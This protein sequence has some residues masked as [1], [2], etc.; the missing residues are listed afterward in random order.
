MKTPKHPKHQSG[1]ALMAAMIALVV[2]AIAAIALIRTVDTGVLVAGNLAFRQ[3]AVSAGDAGIEAARTWMLANRTALNNDTTSEG[4]Y[5]NSQSGVDLTGNT[6]TSTSDDVAWNGTGVSTPKCLATDARGNTVC[7]IIHRM[8]DT[9]GGAIDAATC[10]TKTGSV[11]GSS[12]GG[13]RQMETYQQASWSDVTLFAYYRV[14]VRVAGPRNNI[15][16][17]Q[18]FLII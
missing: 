14:T 12:Q 11:G 3:G 16:F 5:A 8:C 6:T 1:L 10:T 18:A 4:Y 2:M 7:Y 17:V 13:G 9:S 15:S